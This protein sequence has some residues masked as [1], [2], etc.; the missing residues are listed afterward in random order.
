LKVNMNRLVSLLFVLLVTTAAFAATPKNIILFVGDGMGPAHFTAAK[1]LRGADFNIGKIK[2]IGLFTT[3]CAD[4]YV[5]DSAAAASAFATGQKTKY[6]A[7]SVD[8]KGAPRRTV[9]E[10]AKALGKA[11]GLVTTAEF[12]DATPAAFAVHVDYRRK[13]ADV[14]NQM[15]KSGVD[16][17]AGTGAQIFGKD[18]LPPLPDLAKQY[19][20]TLITDPKAIDTA[21]RSH[22]LVAFES[23]EDDLDTPGAPLPQLARWALD[24]VSTNPNGFFLLVEEEGTDGSS[25]SNNA[26]NVTK[27][28]RS[29]D[30][31]VG[32]GLDFASK[33]PDTLVL[34]LGDHETGGMRIY[35]TRSGKFR[36]E[37]STVEH[38]ATAIPVFSLGPGSER[39]TGFFDNTDI[40]KTLL[41]FEGA[42]PAAMTSSAGTSDAA[43][44]V[45]AVV[46]DI[47]IANPTFIAGKQLVTTQRTA[48]A[49]ARPLADETDANRLLPKGVLRIDRF[50]IQGDQANVMIWTG[51]IPTAPPGRASLA[52]GSGHGFTLQRGADGR[53]TIVSRSVA[54]C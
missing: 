2:T 47:G 14:T 4:R 30:E 49:S 24:R 38:T 20:Y 3:F 44:V 53:W 23:Q 40:G 33:H 48:F 5:T 26:K 52:C 35:E 21:S 29:F 43:A 22:A 10:A 42:A 45:D 37:W 28:L 13:Y 16:V 41:S 27:A 1:N 39:F 50:D 54:Q 8:E 46:A 15:L 6:E 18:P 25:H 7:L 32:V 17:I 51:P 19:G 11:T 12:Y 34:V 9:L 36:I 31:A